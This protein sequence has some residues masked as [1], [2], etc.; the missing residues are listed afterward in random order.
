MALRGKSYLAEQDFEFNDRQSNQ[1]VVKCLWRCTASWARRYLHQ[2]HVNATAVK[3]VAATGKLSAPLAVTEAI[4][5]DNATGFT[6]GF[7]SPRDAE[8]W[9]V[10]KIMVGIEAETVESAA[11]EEEV[12]EEEG[13]ETD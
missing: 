5:A 13:G 1:I 3:E 6:C 10:L 2:P 8:A 7:G 12:E 9:E 4:E 11:E